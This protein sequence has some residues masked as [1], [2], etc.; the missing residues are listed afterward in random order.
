MIFRR[1]H[2]S[3]TENNSEGYGYITNRE[4][5]K[6]LLKIPIIHVVIFFLSWTPYTVMATWWVGYILEGFFFS[7]L[8]SMQNISNLTSLS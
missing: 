8:A 1:S 3:D 6:K 5:M 2:V 4:E 7:P